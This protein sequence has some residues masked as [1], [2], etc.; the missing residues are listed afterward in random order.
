MVPD[1]G[2]FSG[3]RNIDVHANA[4]DELKED[5]NSGPASHSRAATGRRLMHSGQLSLIHVWPLFQSVDPAHLLLSDP[6]IRCPRTGV[7]GAAFF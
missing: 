1:K 7:Y 4:I 2:G 6:F 3:A 5:N